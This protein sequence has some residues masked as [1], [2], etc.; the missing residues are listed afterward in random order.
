MNYYEILE[1]SPKASPLVIRAAYKS[2]MQRYHP[3]KDSGD[4]ERA[5]LVV[6]AY[7]V[8]SDEAKRS[9]YDLL[10]NDLLKRGRHNEPSRAQRGNP[11][12]T[13]EAQGDK[14]RR[15]SF[16]WLCLLLVLIY[17]G[18]T[19]VFPTKPKPS[20]P[21]VPQQ[22]L[23]PPLQTQPNA[24]IAP[25]TVRRP[26]V[27]RV[28]VIAREF[29]AE[30]KKGEGSAAETRFTLRIPELAVRVGAV[31]PESAIKHLENTADLIRDKLKEN[32]AKA[33]IEELD[34]ADG[35]RY[36]TD[37]ILGVMSV[38]SEKAKTEPATTASESAERYGVIEILL[39]KYYS[40]R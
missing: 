34:K 29:E 15:W 21:A 5:A 3:D 12:D 6:Q 24:Q 39:P 35:E 8:L 7:D 25:E 9:S 1:V 32:L 28:L 23:P 31:D 18:W 33:S 13:R 30:L 16:V 2:L 11:R 20:P 10:L 37:R 14:K 26:P 4:A 27:S 19:R 22:S 17:L 40:L 38:Q 36:L